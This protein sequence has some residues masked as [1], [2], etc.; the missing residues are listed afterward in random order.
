V[1]KTDFFEMYVKAHAS[2]FTEKTIKNAFKAT[3]IHPFNPGYVLDDLL[4]TPSPPST[5]DGEPISSPW[6][7][8]TPLTIRQLEKQVSVINS[9]IQDKEDHTMPLEKISKATRHLMAKSVLMETR[10][11]ELESTVQFLNKKKHRS[12]ARLQIGGVVSV[13]EAQDRIERADLAIQIAT[14]QR[15]QRAAPT[16]SLCHQLGHKRNACPSIQV[17]SN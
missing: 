1:D 13:E 15:R 12:K 5:I 6:N 7:S 4:S 14:E 8:G 17:T 3:G 11:A 9:V 16:C 10:V 2:I